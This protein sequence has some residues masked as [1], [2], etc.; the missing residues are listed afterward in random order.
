[1][2]KLPAFCICMA[3]LNLK[4]DGITLHGL[5][6]V[7]GIPIITLD[8]TQVMVL[9]TGVSDYAPLME[10]KV[11]RVGRNGSC[12]G[13]CYPELLVMGMGVAMRGF[14]LVIPDIYG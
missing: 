10:G 14:W 8:K 5:Q 4:G 13:S 3:L 6:D 11:V 7:E 9:A 12:G 1:M 2:K